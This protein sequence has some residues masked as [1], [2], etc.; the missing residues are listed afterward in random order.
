MLH[1]VVERVCLPAGSTVTHDFVG[2]RDSKV[3][4]SLECANDGLRQRGICSLTTGGVSII[5][6]LD[7]NKSPCR[8]ACQ[9]DLRAHTRST[10][11]ADIRPVWK[12]ARRQVCRFVVYPRTTWKTRFRSKTVTQRRAMNKRQEKYRGE[13]ARELGH[14]LIFLGNGAHRSV[15][16]IAA[17]DHQWSSRG[18]RNCFN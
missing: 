4:S 2:W 16:L 17:D 8:R 18:C 15:I 7:R 10:T 3:A 1:G 12:K 11:L 13:M 5:T 9:G 14:I 6:I